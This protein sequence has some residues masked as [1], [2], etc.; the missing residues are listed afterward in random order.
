M[1]FENSKTVKV[2]SGS[3]EESIDNTDVTFTAGTGTGT[4]SVME[5]AIAAPDEDG[6]FAGEDLPFTDPVFG[7]FKLAFGGGTPTQA[8]MATFDFGT[9]GGNVATLTMTDSKGNSETIEFAYDSAK[10]TAG[11][12]LELADNDG[13]YIVVLEG[14]AVNKDDYV[15]INQDDFAHLL[16]VTDMEFSPSDDEG[17]IDLKDVFTGT[18]Y[19]V[20]LDEGTTN[21][22]NG[23]KI[24]DGKT[25]K[26]WAHD[27]TTDGMRVVWG[28]G[29]THLATSSTPDR[30]DTNV[31]FPTII[32]E[33]G[34]EVAFVNV[35]NIGTNHDGEYWEILGI[36]VTLNDTG[37][38]TGTNIDYTYANST[39][40]LI[41][42]ES[43]TGPSVLI[44][45]EEGEDASG[46][47]VQNAVIVMTE[48]D[49]DGIEIKSSPTLTCAS[50]GSYITLGSDDDE[51]IAGDRYGALVH[52]DGEDQGEATV[53]YPDNQVVMAVGIGANPVFSTS[54]ESGTVQEAYQITTPITKLAS[55]VTGSSITR[56]AILVGGPCAN[57][58]VA[59][60]MGVSSAW[61]DCAADFENLNE[62]MIKEYTDAFGTGQKALVVAGATGPDTRA[63]AAKVLAGTMDYEA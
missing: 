35:T 7:T 58:L 39:T 12:E 49:S 13:D 59:E 42:I 18:T 29:S 14:G 56:D 51:T 28:S 8:E 22:Y 30:G 61:P 62:G 17:E 16:E 52:F 55:E 10:S 60:L 63:L 6:D 15:V 32:G 31:I 45:E 19:T 34:A 41:T 2:G 5:I 24:I 25:Y 4:I 26:F 47:D 11:T 44:L 40:G 37:T 1:T 33:D 43:V 23:T 48:D 27:T 54:G 36:N 20:A 46:D 9:S 50:A 21:Y 3:D 38:L 57:A 53:Y